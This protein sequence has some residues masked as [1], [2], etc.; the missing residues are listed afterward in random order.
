MKVLS[1]YTLATDG[2][3]SV[4][5][6]INL[7]LPDEPVRADVGVTATG[8]FIG[9]RYEFDNADAIVEYKGAVT[10]AEKAVL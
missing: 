6:P 1:S 8:R 7:E 3:E 9:L 4:S 10:K 2:T 5:V